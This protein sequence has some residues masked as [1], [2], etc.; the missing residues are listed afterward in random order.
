[1]L[2]SSRIKRLHFVGI[3]GAGMSGIAEI[4]HLSGFEISGSD[5]GR[6]P[7]IEYLKNLG[8]K[9]VHE[10]LA[11]NVENTD[12]VVYSSAVKMDNPEL[13]R[14]K[15]LGTP[16]IRRAEMLGELMRL[17]Y[18]LAVAGTHG[19]TTTTSLI[20]HIWK[21]A[22]LAPTIIVGGIVKS[23]GTGAVHGE[24]SAL[25][26]EADEYDK[27]FLEMV[28]SMAVITNIEADHLDCYDDLD[29]IKKAFVQFANKIPFYGQVIACVD[30]EGVRDVLAS[31]KKPVVSYGFARQADY[32]V[33]KYEAFPEGSMVTVAGREGIL[34]EFKM[35]LVGKHNVCNAL[36]AVAIASEENIS[37]DVIAK[38]LASFSGVKRRFEV[39]GHFARKGVWVID[40]YAHHPTE[41]AATLEGARARFAHCKIIVIFQPHLYT[42]TRDHYK[43]FASAFLNSD[44]LILAP[45]YGAREEPLEGVNS[46]LIAERTRSLGH[47]QVTVI[48]NVDEIPQKIF[49]HLSDYLSD[50]LSEN[51]AKQEVAVFT[52]GAGPIYR[53]GLKLVELLEAES[54]LNGGV[55]G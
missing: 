3:G 20:G 14:A 41:V 55:D 36:A 35:N 15:E 21:E 22:G 1:M 4:L 50:R 11:E 53:Q 31:I 34:G 42:R 16:V 47:H 32:R 46:Q 7:V 19:K 33:E 52:I 25:I 48:E 29:D 9:V 23:M 39:L 54:S 18:T 24:G 12:L 44:E 5:Y 37:F 26:A 51:G 49:D 2:P 27:S 8:I 10:H 45:I 38:A 17:R 6:G 43:S 28:P 13:I 40:D 30:D